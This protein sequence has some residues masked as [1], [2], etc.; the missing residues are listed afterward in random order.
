MA[1]EVKF[2]GYV[3]RV[4]QFDWGVVYD[5]AHNQVVKNQA[6][7]WET[8]GK[9]YFQVVGPAGLQEGQAVEVIGRLKTKT[10]DK[11]DG[12]KGISLQV[13]ASSIEPVQTRGKAAESPV[14][15]QWPAAREIPDNTIPF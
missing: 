11:S 8:V 13:R 6:G 4:K 5:I 12:S 10:F 7:E 15:A 14:V 2:S 3:N 9:D 1:I